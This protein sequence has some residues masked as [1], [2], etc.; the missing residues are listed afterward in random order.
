MLLLV[1]VLQPRVSR[2]GFRVLG[3]NILPLPME[4]HMDKNMVSTPDNMAFIGVYG[5]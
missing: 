3:S 4:N 1:F 5:V 2:L